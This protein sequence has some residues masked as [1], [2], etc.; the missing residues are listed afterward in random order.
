MQ[1]SSEKHAR[2]AMAYLR[3]DAAPQLTLAQKRE[4][5]QAAARHHALARMAAKWEKRPLSLS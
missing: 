5:Q 4:L 1:W 3:D 2:V